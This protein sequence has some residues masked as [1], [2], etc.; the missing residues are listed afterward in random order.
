MR[1][2]TE[3]ASENS[4]E[5]KNSEKQFKSHGAVQRQVEFQL[6]EGSSSWEFRSLSSLAVWSDQE[7]ELVQLVPEEFKELPV[8]SKSS[9]RN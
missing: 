5:L 8:L 2:R 4:K 9:R 6:R 7:E 1:S 3:R